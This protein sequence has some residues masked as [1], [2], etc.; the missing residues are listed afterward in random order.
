[1]ETQEIPHIDNN[2]NEVE[3]TNDTNDKVICENSNEAKVIGENSNKSITENTDEEVVEDKTNAAEG[4]DDDEVYDPSTPVKYRV[5]RAVQ[6]YK[7]TRMF[8]GTSN[9]ILS[10]YFHF[11]G[12]SEDT[13]LCASVDDPMIPNDMEVDFTYNVKVYLSSYIMNETGYVKEDAFR[14]API[15]I[16]SFLNYLVRRQVCPEYLEDMQQ[17]IKVAQLAKEELLNCKLLTQDAP[18]KFNKACSLLFGGELYGRF[19]NP[20]P[21]EDSLA[22]LFG[23]HPEEAKQIL[24]KIFGDN[25]LNELTEVKE[26]CKSGLTV[27][28][29]K[30][31]ELPESTT[32]ND[33]TN[34][35]EDENDDEWL[36]SY[37]IREFEVREFETP[38]AETFTI[39]V[40]PDLAPY[41]MVGMLI[42]ADFHRLSNGFWYWDNTIYVYP[43]YYTKPEDSDSEE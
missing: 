9:Q 10:S 39:A 26:A 29:I 28:I 23:I 4:Q 31:N 33:T 13:T 21:S 25:A 18:G 15:V 36:R 7:A 2:D 40:G 30:V 27:E 37:Y 11:G 35:T 22:L 6:K 19:D 8:D 3:K 17:A 14:E 5:E 24:K 12:I 41:P 38:D 16:E 32:A 43:S 1:M 42:N 34:D 20:Y